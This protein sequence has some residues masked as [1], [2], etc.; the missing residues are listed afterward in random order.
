[1]ATK[2]P[3]VSTG[4]RPNAAARLLPLLAICCL[5]W[6]RAPYGQREA[7]CTALALLHVL[8]RPAAGSPFT[9]AKRVRCITPGT[10]VAHKVFDHLRRAGL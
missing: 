9:S 5:G 10:A 8:R 4:A 1:M 6:G 3:L 2:L 7:R